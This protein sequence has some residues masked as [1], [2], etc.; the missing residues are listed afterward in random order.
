LASTP[1]S[2]G[3]AKRGFGAVLG[4]V[5]FL[6]SPLSWWNDLFINVPL[7]LA[8]AWVVSCIHRGAFTASFILGYWLTNVLGFV[9]LHRGA[10]M[11]LGRPVK[12]YDGKQIARDIVISLLYTVLIVLLVELGL[13]APLPDYLAHFQGGVT[14]VTPNEPL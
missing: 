11:T 4:V 12:G 9:L 2:L 5:G 8:F 14:F 1:P 13:V 3:I 6:L 7:A 10:E